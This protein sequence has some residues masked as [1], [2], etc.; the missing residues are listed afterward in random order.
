MIETLICSVHPYNQTYKSYVVCKLINFLAESNYDV[1]VVPVSDNKKYIKD[2]VVNLENNFKLHESE[3][4]EQKTEIVRKFVTELNPESE[5]KVIILYGL[6]SDVFKLTQTIKGFNPKNITTLAFIDFEHEGEN[7][8]MIREIDKNCN[9]VVVHHQHWHQYYSKVF[10]KPIHV[11][12]SYIE[13]M[14]PNGL[15]SKAHCREKYNIDKETILFS[16]FHQNLKQSRTD[17]TVIA[18]LRFL[19]RLKADEQ[20]KDDF[21]NTKILIVNQTGSEFNIPD[22][23][24]N[25]D[26]YSEFRENIMYIA[27][28]ETYS[29]D[30]LRG[31]ENT[32]DIAISTNDYDDNLFKAMQLKLLHKPQIL[33]K[34]NM[35]KLTKCRHFKNDY[36]IE[37][38]TTMYNGYQ[39]NQNGG[40][41]YVFKIDDVVNQMYKAFVAFKTGTQEPVFSPALEK[42]ID[43]YEDNLVLKKIFTEAVFDSKM[44][45]DDQ[46]A[47]NSIFNAPNIYNH[48]DV[49]YE[50]AYKTQKESK[51][52]LEEDRDEL[53]NKVP[54]S[55]SAEIITLEPTMNPIDFVKNDPVL[56]SIMSTNSS[57]IDVSKIKS[58]ESEVE[59]KEHKEKLASFKQEVQSSKQ[60]LNKLQDLLKKRK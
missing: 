59:Q 10:T 2:H 18:F 1:S 24:R 17:I 41:S 45:P 57:N 31:L 50:E 13:A 52:R 5:Q 21:P 32:C 19:K 4:A 55:T 9:A 33:I 54:I 12:E 46:K 27:N 60:K 35:M 34:S 7:I 38:E 26:R 36:L 42:I 16:N 6:L 40:K 25:E 29:N 43:T 22:L 56:T 11:Y 58:I 48:L 14:T 3:T 44:E 39:T 20:Y 8:K 28:T 37:P 51:Q 23:L 49:E 47:Y 15:A 53:K 30:L